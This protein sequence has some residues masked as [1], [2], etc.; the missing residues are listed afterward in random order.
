M[1]NYKKVLYLIPALTVVPMLVSAQ[2]GQL[3]VGTT[4]IGDKDDVIGFIGEVLNWVFGILLVVG[5]IFILIAA[6]KYLTA[7]GDE[8]Q[9]ASAKNTLKYALIGIALAFVSKAIVLVLASIFDV[10]VSGN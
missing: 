7:A 3:D 9:V 4:R 10:D 8:K 6:Y 5:V 1:K 2:L